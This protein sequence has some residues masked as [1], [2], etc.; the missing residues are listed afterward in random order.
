MAHV[1]DPLPCPVPPHISSWWCGRTSQHLLGY[2]TSPGELPVKMEAPHGT[3]AGVLAEVHRVC[4]HACVYRYVCVC[5]AIACASMHTCMHVYANPVGTLMH[6]FA[7]VHGSLCICV[8]WHIC[9]CEFEDM[10]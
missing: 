6:M 2:H 10:K 4:M 7:Q 9:V 3:H 8:C 1:G 5:K